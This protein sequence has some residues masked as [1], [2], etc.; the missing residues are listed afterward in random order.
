MWPDFSGGAL[1]EIVAEFRARE[2]RFGGV[3]PAPAG[4]HHLR[5]SR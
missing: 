5:L 3:A 1:E 2:R 4:H